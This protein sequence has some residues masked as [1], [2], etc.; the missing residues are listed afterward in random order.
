MAFVGLDAFDRL[1]SMISSQTFSQHVRRLE[2]EP[3]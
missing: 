3:H 2:A 1:E